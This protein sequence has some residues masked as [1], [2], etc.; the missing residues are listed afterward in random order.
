[1]NLFILSF[2]VVSLFRL[3]VVLIL[4]RIWRFCII[5][6]V[7]LQKDSIQLFIF[8]ALFKRSTLNLHSR[9]V[10]QLFKVKIFRRNAFHKI[11][12]P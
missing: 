9:S 6:A 7:S 2:G 10:Y 11:K 8:F 1:M 12:L 3:R 5:L 4:F